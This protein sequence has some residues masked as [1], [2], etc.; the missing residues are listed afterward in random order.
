LIL[1]S[2]VAVGIVGM[3]LPQQSTAHASSSRPAVESATHVPVLL[4]H[5]LEG[6]NAANCTTSSNDYDRWGGF[7]QVN[8]AYFSGLHWDRKLLKTLGFYQSDYSCDDYLG[9]AADNY[10]PCLGYYD[11]NERTNNED[12]RHLACRFYWYVYDNYTVN[13]I[14]VNIL[15]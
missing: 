4:L 14:P 9:T 7:I 11:G 8:N 10:R 2:V 3:A 15:A 1:V 5:G 12:I 6:Y 13:G